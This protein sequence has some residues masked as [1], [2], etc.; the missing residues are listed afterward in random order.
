MAQDDRLFLFQP[1]ST[2]TVVGWAEFA[3]MIQ[4]IIERDLREPE[5][6]RQRIDAFEVVPIVRDHVPAGEDRGAL[7]GDAPNVSALQGGT[8]EFVLL[9]S[10]ILASGAGPGAY[11]NYAP[12][13]ADVQAKV[14]RIQA[15]CERHAVPLAAAA[16]EQLQIDALGL[17][18][19]VRP[20]KLL[21]PAE[22][23]VELLDQHR[24]HRP[25]SLGRL[26]V[27]RWKGPIGAD[28]IG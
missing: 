13:P 23:L 19:L 15:V 18:E 8:I 12:A 6:H 16:L 17:D 3:R 4:P 20:A 25:P 27:D 21:E 1:N 14:G 10:G 24:V 11:Y 22:Q 28:Q 9:N 2:N 26:W 7:G 5:R